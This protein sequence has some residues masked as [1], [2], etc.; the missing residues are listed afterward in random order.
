[1]YQWALKPQKVFDQ[2]LS[3]VLFNI[4]LEEALGIWEKKC[5]MGMPIGDRMLYTLHYTDNQVAVL[6]TLRI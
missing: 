1:M 6:R 4:Y 3:P 5:N 2:G